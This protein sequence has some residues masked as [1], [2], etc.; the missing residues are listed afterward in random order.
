MY[1]A[2]IYIINENKLVFEGIFLQS[3]RKFTNLGTK[4]PIYPHLILQSCSDT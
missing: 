2:D 1:T 3:E 4:S